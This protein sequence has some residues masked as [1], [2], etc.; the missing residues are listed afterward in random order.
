MSLSTYV[1][2]VVLFALAAAF[3]RLLGDRR[4]V[5]RAAA[6]QPGEARRLRVRHRADAAAAQRRPVPGQVLPDRDALH[7][8]RHRD[9]LPLPVG[10]RQPTRSAC[11]G[12]S[13]WSCSSSPCSSRTPTS[14]GA[15][16]W[17]GTDEE[18]AMGLEE[19]LPERGPADH[20]R[21][22]GQLDAQVVAVA[23]DVRPGLLRHRDDGLRRAALRPGP[24]RH[25][26]LPRLAAAGRPDDRRRPGEPED[27]AGAAADLR[28]DARAEV[29]ARDG[30]LRQLAAACSTTTRSS[31][32]S[33]TSSRSTC[34]CPAARRGRRC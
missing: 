30:R 3:A 23:G 25:G 11:S 1:P 29:G 26:G 14:G 4:A 33:T 12:W 2:I 19:K 22:A 9:H 18:L 6:L 21:E 27:G 32:A 31:R 5:H 20:R 8:L 13:R 24:L 15:A 17:T 16:A 10:R 28:P 34:T 7:R